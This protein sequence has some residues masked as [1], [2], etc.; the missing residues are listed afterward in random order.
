M[1]GEIKLMSSQGD[2]RT[3]AML[4]TASTPIR[5]KQ[6]FGTDLLTGIMKDGDFDLDV[7]SKLAY[8]MANQ[9]AHA[10]LK[11]LD[12]NKYIDWLDD[13]DSMAFMDNVQDILS[14]YFRSEER[15]SQAKKGVARPRVK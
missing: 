5:F 9:A 2:E 12:M 14:V 8:L 10:D 1:Y 4:A 15:R 13:F 6:L 7:I 11:T 3:I